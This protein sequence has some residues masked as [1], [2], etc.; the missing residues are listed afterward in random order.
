MTFE[1][2]FYYVHNSAHLTRWVASYPPSSPSIS[3]WHPPI[4]L[5]L[6]KLIKSKNATGTFHFHP[7]SRHS[8]RHPDTQTCVTV[9]LD[10]L[11]LS[12]NFH[13]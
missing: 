13:P 5:V 4:K 7:S 9:A 2:N 8:N 6:N 10:T 12:I 1:H 3:C 11:H